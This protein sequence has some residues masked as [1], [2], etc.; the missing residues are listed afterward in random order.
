MT[1]DTLIK[2]FMDYQVTRHTTNDYILN[3]KWPDRKFVTNIKGSHNG[4]Q[5]I[6]ALSPLFW[7]TFWRYDIISMKIG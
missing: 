7:C 1:E 5:D 6:I 3:I 4:K 2:E